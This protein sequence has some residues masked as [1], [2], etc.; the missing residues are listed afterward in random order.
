MN[1]GSIGS[2]LKLI[3]VFPILFALCK[4]KGFKLNRLSLYY[5]GFFFISFNTIIWSINFSSTINRC[6]S[7]FEF[8]A[9]ISSPCFFEFSTKEYEKI[10]KALVWSSRITVILLLMF[11]SLYEGRLT[12]SGI[13]NE[14]PNYICMYFSFGL[15]AAVE[16]TMNCENKKYRLFSA[17]EAALYLYCVLLTGSRGGLMAIA[18]CFISATFLCTKGS[19]HN[20]KK[21]IQKLMIFILGILAFV[22]LVQQLAPDIIQRFTIE[23]VVEKGGTGRTKIWESGIDLFKNSSIFREL[24]GYGS[25]TVL[26]SLQSH[27]YYNAAVMHNIYLENLIELGLIG[28]FYYIAMIICFFKKSI[29]FHSK[30]STCVL[31]GFIVMCLSTSLYSFKPYINLLLFIVLQC[32]L[33]E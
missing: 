9:L 10:K 18:A 3:G 13:I 24:F 23:S 30:F 1:I 27:G 15:V 14:D 25:A 29:K 7:I 28:F 31:V 12:L 4:H 17:G 21:D 22:I 20:F 32:N 8:F 26:R 19:V 6:I 16:Q 2:L 11:G 33:K 5:L